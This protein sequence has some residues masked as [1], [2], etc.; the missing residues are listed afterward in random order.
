LKPSAIDEQV[1][2]G[3]LVARPEH[4]VV[5]EQLGA[6]VEELRQGLRA[7]VGVE[8][9]LL[10]DPQPRQLAALPGQLVAHP[11]VLLLALQQLLAGSRPLLATHDLVLG[12]HALLSGCKSSGGWAVRCGVVAFALLVG[13]TLATFSCDIAR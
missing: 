1:G 11:G 10:L 7:V 13:R 9:V 5:D 2:A 6:A 12:H 3:G 8:A 4:E